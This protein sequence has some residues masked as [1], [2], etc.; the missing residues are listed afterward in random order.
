MSTTI[1]NHN[2]KCF[3]AFDLRPPGRHNTITS[4]PT[5]VQI[6]DDNYLD[7]GLIMDIQFDTTE[8][9]EKIEI[10][11]ENEGSS[12]KNNNNFACEQCGK[13]FAVA[14]R[15][16]EHLDFTHLGLRNINCDIC[17]KSFEFS[18]TLVQHKR[19]KHTAAG[20]QRF[21]CETCGYASK[22]KQAL[23]AH[24]R[25]HRGEKPY[26]CDLCPKSFADQSCLIKH[27]RVHS[28]ENKTQCSICGQ[29][30]S[31][32]QLKIHILNKHSKS[33]D[34]RNY[35]YS[36][37]VKIEAVRLAEKVGT[38]K[39]AEMLNLKYMVVRKWRQGISSPTKLKIEKPKQVYSLDFK[40]LVAKY[41]ADVTPQ[42][43]AVKFCV[44]ESTVRRWH[45][46][47][48]NSVFCDECG[49]PF[50][51]QSELNKHMKSRH[52]HQY[53]NNPVVQH[54]NL[55][56]KV[57][58]KIYEVKWMMENKKINGLIC[59]FVLKVVA[60]GAL[61]LY[62]L[63]CTS[64]SVRLRHI[65]HQLIMVQRVKKV[66][67]DKAKLAKASRL[68]ASES[69]KILKSE[70]EIK[71][72]IVEDDE[73][74]ESVPEE[75]L[76]HEY[77]EVEMNM[78]T[79]SDGDN[80]VMPKIETFDE[81]ISINITRKEPKKKV[82]KEEG[83]D[84]KLNVDEKIDI[85]NLF[86]S[87]NLTKETEFDEGTNTNITKKKPRKKE[88]KKEGTSMCQKC[89]KTFT[90]KHH[91]SLLARHKRMV[92]CETK[93]VDEFSH[94]DSTICTECG[95]DFKRKAHLREHMRTHNKVEEFKCIACGESFSDR[96]SLI[97]H[98]D[99]FHPDMRDLFKKNSVPEKCNLC[100]VAFRSKR[101]MRQHKI[102]EHGFEYPY[103]CSV[104]LKGFI[105]K[106]RSRTEPGVCVTEK[107]HHQYDG[108]DGQIIHVPG[109]YANTYLYDQESVKH[110]N[111]LRRKV[112]N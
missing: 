59:I 74:E 95:K 44:P 4:Q 107:K 110:N 80:Y 52:G 34:D 87:A 103:R 11:K 16:Q 17:F 76:M 7:L 49:E 109:V 90:G 81:P 71:E 30:V 89:G 24:T 86:A 79:D 47:Y 84:E 60:F 46:M 21:Q 75:Y 63:H 50:P 65:F 64:K 33:D 91:S 99:T 51:Y 100:D 92:K 78:D 27:L 20:H 96:K 72:E 43:A 68:L 93:V 1:D 108:C 42:E 55:D 104:C 101:E 18:K 56:L 83:I 102:D 41:A 28:G 45:T 5:A 39:A 32:K 62:Y 38:F 77:G 94:V 31:K 106:D 10:K 85:G 8:K 67:K 22:T 6:S 37:E 97:Q 53:N 82:K 40:K 112:Y 13:S 35:T 66:K 26:S 15:L 36:D 3:A 29:E 54:E 57:R 98:A 23:E 9:A 111:M 105:A 12:A 14:K 19:M 61:T 48:H 88:V 70:I 25:R 58:G 73:E 2:G 69:R